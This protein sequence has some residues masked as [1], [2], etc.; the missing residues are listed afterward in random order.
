MC[1]AEE[2]AVVGAAVVEALALR[3]NV[4][5]DKDVLL[6][7]VVLSELLFPVRFVGA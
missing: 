2:V 6:R 4:P 5:I 7:V 3:A 1:F